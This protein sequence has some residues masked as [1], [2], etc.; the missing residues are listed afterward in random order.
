[1]PEA[2]EKIFKQHFKKTITQ[3]EIF[4]NL[5]VFSG[6][7]ELKEIKKAILIRSFQTPVSRS[8]DLFSPRKKPASRASLPKSRSWVSI[9]P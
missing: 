1:M 8:S 4:K 7:Q 5:E 3:R 9:L 2:F 6:K